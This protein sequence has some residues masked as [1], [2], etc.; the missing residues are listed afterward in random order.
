MPEIET[1]AEKNYMSGN[2]L[3]KANNHYAKKDVTRMA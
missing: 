3:L 2:T 1:Q